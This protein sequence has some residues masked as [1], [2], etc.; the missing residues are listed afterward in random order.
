MKVLHF[1]FQ[2]FWRKLVALIFAVAV[3]GQVSATVKKIEAR[4]GARN[5]VEIQS[6]SRMF[7]VG[8]LD[9]GADRLVFFPDGVKQLKVSFRGT[10]KVL[11]DLK[12]EDVLFYV[13]ASKELEPGEHTLP[14]R[15]YSSRPDIKVHSVEPA[16]MKVSVVENPVENRK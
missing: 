3:Y 5:A 16:K 4:R 2:D 8:I 13:V 1:L 14:V 7:T 11:D 15:C 10:K 6:V 12:D 9:L